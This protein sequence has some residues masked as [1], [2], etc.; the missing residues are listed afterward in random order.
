MPI[1]AEILTLNQIFNNL[2]KDAMKTDKQNIIV[3][4][5]NIWS[6]FTIPK[7]EQIDFSCGCLK[8]DSGFV[9]APRNGRM[10]ANEIISPKELAA[11]IN[12]NMKSSF[13]LS[14]FNCF[15]IPKINSFK[16]G[17]SFVFFTSLK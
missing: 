3:I 13:F 11:V 1:E 15:H 17:I 6:D 8:R 14:F 10:D 12:P 16:S 9:K 5:S 7:K 2:S 4:G